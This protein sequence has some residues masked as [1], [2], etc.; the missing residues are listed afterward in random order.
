MITAV[1]GPYVKSGFNGMDVMVSLLR[2][3]GHMGRLVQ[4]VAA[5]TVLTRVVVLK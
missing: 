1:S 5:A 3:H 2:D 4:I